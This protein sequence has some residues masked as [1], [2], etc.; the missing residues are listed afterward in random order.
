MSRTAEGS[1]SDCNGMHA[2][3]GT[4]LNPTFFEDIA[5]AASQEKGAVLVC[6]IGGTIEA[7][8]TNSE[9]FQSRCFAITPQR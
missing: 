9:G 1:R 6:N 5:A 3:Q 7:T 4:E 2:L 8:E